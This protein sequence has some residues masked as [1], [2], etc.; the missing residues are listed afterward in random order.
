MVHK[1]THPRRRI[2]SIPGQVV[3]EKG[4]ARLNGLAKMQLGVVARM[5]G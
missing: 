2:T 4:G 1:S 5:Q 3:E